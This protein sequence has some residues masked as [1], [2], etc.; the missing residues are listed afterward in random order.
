M[1]HPTA[2]WTGDALLVGSRD[3]RQYTHADEGA[4]GEEDSAPC[5][6]DLQLDALAPLFTAEFTEKLQ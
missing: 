5:N 2:T 3:P 4:N 1:L 6:V